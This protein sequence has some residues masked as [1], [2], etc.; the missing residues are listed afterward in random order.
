M[1]VVYKQSWAKTL[2]KFSLLGLGYVLLLSLCIAGT[3]L[4]ALLLTLKLP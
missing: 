4:A 3:A 1:R 2:V